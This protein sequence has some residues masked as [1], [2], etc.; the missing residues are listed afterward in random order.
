MKPSILRTL[1]LAFLAFGLAMGLVFPVYAQFFVEWKEGM[2]GWFIVGCLVAGTSI[3]LFNYFLVNVVLMNKVRRIAAVAQAVSENDVSQQCT[4]QSADVI[5]EIVDSVNRMTANLRG[6]VGQISDSTGQLS[7]A[8]HS[9][10]R[11]SQEVSE[12]VRRQQADTEQAAQALGDIMQM[13]QAVA[14]RAHEAAATAQ[15]ADSEAQGGR[16]I[17]GQ[18]IDAIYALAGDVEQAAA[19]LQQL[20]QQSQNIGVVLDVIRGIA[21]QT[22]LLALNAAIEAA[23]AGEQGRGFAV[24]AD[25][26]RTLATRTQQSTREIQGIIEQLQ[27]GA[28]GTVQIMNAGRSQAQASVEQAR[29]A[30]DALTAIAGAISAIARSTGEIAGAADDQQQVTAT[31]N[32]NVASISADATATANDVERLVAAG[33]DLEGLVARLQELVARFRR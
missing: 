16:L 2:R 21:E 19:A 5:G 27:Q 14:R 3:G 6:M 31:V 8:I 7:G 26:V 24:V 4:L 25:E 1:L 33:T 30:A 12:R 15:Q 13:V 11:T 32:R 20:E 18:T 29:K 23:R 10:A 22:N 28:H 17:I 9:L